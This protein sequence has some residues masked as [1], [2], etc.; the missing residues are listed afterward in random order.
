MKNITHVKI[1]YVNILHYIYNKKNYLEFLNGFRSLHSLRR[2]KKK[3][4]QNI[5]TNHNFEKTQNSNKP[6]S[7]RVGSAR[8]ARTPRQQDTYKKFEQTQT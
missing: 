6:K 1:A 5:Q 2:N 4:I 8:F 3:R 7:F